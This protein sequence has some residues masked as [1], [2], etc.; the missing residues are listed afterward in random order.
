MKKLLFLT[1]ITSLFLFSACN[2]TEEKKDP[3]EGKTFVNENEWGESE[4]YEF[5]NDGTA[6]FTVT[7]KSENAIYTPSTYY[8]YLVDEET[9]TINFMILKY[10]FLQEDNSFVSLDYNEL[11]KKD[12]EGKEA[13]D[14]VFSQIITYK[15]ILMP[16]KLIFAGTYK[17][18]EYKLKK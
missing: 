12:P 7:T 6:C 15:Y 5:S 3:F 13:Y 11:I 8:K 2:K 18:Q 10:P 1:I 14:D 9:E 4:T 16:S 17:N